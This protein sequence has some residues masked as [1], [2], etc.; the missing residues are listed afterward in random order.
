MHARRQS[1]MGD[2][3]IE[4]AHEFSAPRRADAPLGSNGTKADTPIQ[5]RACD[6][7]L[8]TAAAVEKQR[9]FAAGRQRE[10]LHVTA[11]FAAVERFGVPT[12]PW[13]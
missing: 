9:L 8:K 2:E 7:D 6:G 3:M 4:R 10:E 12:G 11:Q 1:A 13:R 5:G